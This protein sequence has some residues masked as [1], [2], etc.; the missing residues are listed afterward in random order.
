MTGA[1]RGRRRLLPVLLV[2][3]A[4]AAGALA[5]QRRAAVQNWFEDE[6]ADAAAVAELAGADLKQAIAVAAEWPQW[7]GPSRDGRA[8]AGPLRTDWKERPPTVVWSVPGGG[9]YSSPSVARGRVYVQDHDADSRS[10][11][12]R[13]LDTATGA[14]AWEDAYPADYAALRSGYA[15][16]P[17]ASPTVHDGRVYALGATGV[18][19]C[20]QLP[21]DG[22]KPAL[23]WSHDLPAEFRADVPAWGFASSPLIEGDRVI[24]QPGG[25][26]GTVAAFDRVTGERRWAVG[27]NP[28]GYSSPVAATL[29]GVRQIVAVTG[30]A[31][32]GVRPSDGK[33]LWSHD[34]LTPNYGNIA[35]PVVVGDYLFVSS[36]YGKG[37]VLLRVEPAGDGAKAREVYFRKN[38]VMMNHHSTCVHRDGFLYGYDGNDLRC[39][40]LRKGEPVAGWDAIDD[41]GREIR[42]GSVILADQYLVGLTEDGTLFLA[43]A[44]PAEFR[45][46]G[47]LSGVLSGR[48]C[49]AAPVL[50]DGRVYLRDAAKVVCLDVRP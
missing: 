28:N 31:I 45:F 14:V 16:G 18:F 46:R 17:R 10:E 15:G 39:V 20:L 32:L 38:R 11:R 49:W 7:R 41:A 34:W 47:K 48:E 29:G 23:L 4:T 37:C 1:P 42:K 27:K 36:D 3:L 43:D 33:L 50:V 26:D 13:C 21:A 24:V 8:S 9:G 6:R 19:R 22:G 30:D 5:W 2:L 40:D 35:S 44:D 25:K 12:L